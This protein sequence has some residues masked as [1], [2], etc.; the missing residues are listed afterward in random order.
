M[1]TPADVSA[2]GLRACEVA[3]LARGATGSVRDAVHR[4]EPVIHRLR[5]GRHVVPESRHLSRHEPI[6]ASALHAPV[7]LG[8]GARV[9]RSR[10]RGVAAVAPAQGHAWLRAATE[11]VASRSSRRRPA[12]PRRPT[13]PRPRRRD[14]PVRR[15]ARRPRRHRRVARRD[16]DDVRAGSRDG[17][18][19]RPSPTGRSARH[20]LGGAEPLRSTRLPPLGPAPRLDVPRPAHPPHLSPYPAFPPERPSNSRCRVVVGRLSTTRRGIAVC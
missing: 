4:V 1:G 5:I 15:T 2:G 17:P 20:P 10:A 14:D 6:L 12:R 3:P 18:G 16:P 11:A 13:G 19:G 9:G 8:S 7:C